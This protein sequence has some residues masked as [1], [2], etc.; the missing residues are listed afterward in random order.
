MRGSSAL[1]AL[2]W[3]ILGLEGQV[4][5]DRSRGNVRLTVLKNR[6]YGILGVADEF[7]LNPRTWEVELVQ[8]EGF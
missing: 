7:K 1:E 2:S 8:D 4:M 3:I 6:P 5:P